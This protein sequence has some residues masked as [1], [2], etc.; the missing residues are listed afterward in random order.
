[1]KPVRRGL[2]NAHSRAGSSARRRSSKIVSSTGYRW[3]S[4]H[5]LHPAAIMLVLFDL[6]RKKL[7]RPQ[8]AGKPVNAVRLSFWR[9]VKSYAR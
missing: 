3:T 5:L 9:D 6:V 4:S 7:D 2:D 8:A 1:M